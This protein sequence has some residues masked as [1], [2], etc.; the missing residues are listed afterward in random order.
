MDHHSDLAD[1]T[2]QYTY[3]DAIQALAGLSKLVREQRLQMTE[4]ELD[5]IISLCE[6]MISKLIAV[7]EE[8]GRTS[9]RTGAA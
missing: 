5:V 8:R 2:R 7:K 3:D 4:T 6:D 1:K 9:Q